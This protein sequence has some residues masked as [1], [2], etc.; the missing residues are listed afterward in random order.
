LGLGSIANGAHLGGLLVGI[1]TGVIIAR[2]LP[3]G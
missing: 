1:L 3:R 2:V